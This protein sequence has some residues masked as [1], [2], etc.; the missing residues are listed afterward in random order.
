MFIE[1]VI[2]AVIAIVSCLIEYL[3]CKDS[4]WVIL[5]A[6]VSVNLTILLL[7]LKE[8]CIPLEIFYQVII[9]VLIVF[10]SKDKK[11]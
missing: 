1:I 9:C 6:I 3:I 11:C 4:N 8:L 7:L 10:I 2:C 5:H